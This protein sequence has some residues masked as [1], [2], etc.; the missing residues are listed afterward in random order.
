MNRMPPVSR[1]IRLFRAKHFLRL[2]NF[3]ARAKFRKADIDK[4]RQIREPT[5]NRLRLLL[6]GGYAPLE[7]LSRGF[8]WGISP[9]RRNWR[10]RKR[11]RRLGREKNLGESKKTPA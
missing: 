10:R 1:T 9:T 2:A 7:M 6:Q 8:W 4:R 5:L 11:F 3:F